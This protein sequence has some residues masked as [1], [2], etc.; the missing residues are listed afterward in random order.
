MLSLTRQS[1]LDRVKDALTEAVS[2]T[3]EIVH[4]KRLRSNIQSAV[5]HG[6]E[7]RD[8]LRKDVGAARITTR[9]MT[10]RKL[11]KNLRAL[12]DDIDRVGE[13]MRRRRTHRVRNAMLIVAGTGAAVAIVSP[14]RRWVASQMS[15]S[16]NGGPPPEV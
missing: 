6:A 3:D 8:R 11:R 9:L 16:E 1:R 12:I 14:A 10:D 13:R 15:A 4:D 7:A 5:D 2:Y